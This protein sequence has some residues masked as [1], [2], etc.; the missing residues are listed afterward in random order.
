MISDGDT[1]ICDTLVCNAA[2][3]RRFL[4]YQSCLLRYVHEFIIYVHEF[5]I[6]VHEFIIYVSP[7][8]RQRVSV[9]TKK[10]VTNI[11]TIGT[12]KIVSHEKKIN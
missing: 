2:R 5:I 3:E 8:A 4:R 12:I 1:V 7:K 9:V 10:K 6:Y 11:K